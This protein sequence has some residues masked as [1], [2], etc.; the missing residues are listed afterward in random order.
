VAR[1]RLAPLNIVEYPPSGWIDFAYYLLKKRYR[2]FC[3]KTIYVWMVCVVFRGLRVFGVLGFSWVQ[4]GLIGFSRFHGSKGSNG[5]WSLLRVSG[6]LRVTWVIRS[7]RSKGYICLMVYIGSEES[8][9]SN[10]PYGRL[11]LRSLKG[12]KVLGFERIS[13]VQEVDRSPRVWKDVNKCLMATKGFKTW[14][15]S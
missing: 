7:L 13:W 14:K 10:S 9:G 8:M 1:H 4:S 12:V 3:K 2:L 15:G 6:L 11:V 5:F